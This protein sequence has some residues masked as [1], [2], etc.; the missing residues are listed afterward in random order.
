MSVRPASGRARR[1]HAQVDHVTRRL[2][3]RPHRAYRLGGAGV[4]ALQVLA[5][6]GAGLQQV[7]RA[8][9]HPFHAGTA[10]G[11]ERL[12]RQRGFQEAAGT[13]GGVRIQADRGL[14]VAEAE[15]ADVAAEERLALETHEHVQPGVGLEVV[16]DHR[17]VDALLLQRCAELLAAHG[18]IVLKAAGRGEV[19]V[20]VGDVG[21][22][23]QLGAIAEGVLGRPVVEIRCRS[24]GGKGGQ[25][26][27]QQGGNRAHVGCG[28]LGL[29]VDRTSTAARAGTFARTRPAVQPGPPAS[30]GSGGAAPV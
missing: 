30:P 6:I 17:V 28:S 1:R 22:G 19:V 20:V 21:G 18:I 13:R 15:T 25:R 5:A 11:V 29:R 3:R 12:H 27:G 4:V 8:L 26:Q 14:H 9:Q 24:E 23:G 7:L 2:H 10:A 16:V